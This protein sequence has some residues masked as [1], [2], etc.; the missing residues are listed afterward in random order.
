MQGDSI[1]HV[2][3]FF[4]DSAIHS[5]YVGIKGPLDPQAINLMRRIDCAH[6]PRSVGCF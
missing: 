5:M 3:T 1:H 6:L 4:Q 2:V